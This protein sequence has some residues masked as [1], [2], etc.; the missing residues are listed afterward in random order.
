MEWFAENIGILPSETLDGFG[1]TSSW[2][3]GLVA[4]DA[5]TTS[6]TDSG[7]TTGPTEIQSQSP[8]PEPGTLTLLPGALIALA[9]FRR[10][11]RRS[12]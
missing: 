1:I 4:F 8:V 2:G 3:P 6:F 10:Y 7:T 9:T 12:T 11:A 5:I